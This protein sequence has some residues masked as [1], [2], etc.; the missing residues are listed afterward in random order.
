MPIG[1][2]S[3][4]LNPWRKKCLIMPRAKCPKVPEFDFFF[5]STP[6][7]RKKSFWLRLWFSYTVLKTYMEHRDCTRIP[8]ESATAPSFYAESGPFQKRH[9]IFRN[10]PWEPFEHP[11]PMKTVSIQAKTLPFISSQLSWTSRSNLRLRSK[12]SQKTLCVKEMR[13][14]KMVPNSP[15]GQGR[16]PPPPVGGRGQGPF[17]RHYIEPQGGRRA[18]TAAAAARRRRTSYGR[19]PTTQCRR[20]TPIDNAGQCHERLALVYCRRPG[21]SGPPAPLRQVQSSLTS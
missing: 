13:E 11:P 20:G 18:T 9:P 4:P 7:P 5:D 19:K 1:P 8:W 14:V 15:K 3:F 6:P 10:S 2:L 12:V 21:A 17:T 16:S